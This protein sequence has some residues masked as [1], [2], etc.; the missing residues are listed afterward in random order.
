MFRCSLI[1]L[2]WENLPNN[3]IHVEHLFYSRIFSDVLEAWMD[4][5]LGKEVGR[6]FFCSTATARVKGNLY[7]TFSLKSVLFATTAT[8]KYRFQLAA[9]CALFGWWERECIAW[10]STFRTISFRLLCQARCRRWISVSMVIDDACVTLLN[11]FED[12]TFVFSR[13]S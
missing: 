4:E 6:L 10:N 7:S 13:L 5:L 9:C 2:C 1:V 12:E 3:L 11:S 8:V